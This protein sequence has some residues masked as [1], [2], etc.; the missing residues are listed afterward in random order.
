MDQEK[1]KSLM[2]AYGNAAYKK[3][4]L[5]MEKQKLIDGILTD[6][7]KLKLA[8]I[9]AEFLGKENGIIEE[10]KSSRKILDRAIV[11]YTKELSVGKDKI[12]FKSPLMTLTVSE[13][14]VTW[15]VSAIDAYAISGHPELLSFRKVGQPKTRLTRNK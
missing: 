4:V 7:I 15:D 10:E 13:P 2:D 12:Y 6:E 8:E 3:D 9:D 14:E 5:Q 1:L 11:E